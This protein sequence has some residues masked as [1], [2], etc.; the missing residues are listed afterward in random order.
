MGQRPLGPVITELDAKL[1]SHLPE[2]QQY[3]NVKIFLKLY[4]IA[5]TSALINFSN[6]T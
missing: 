4:E 6:Y 3:Q 1:V 5:S 2:R